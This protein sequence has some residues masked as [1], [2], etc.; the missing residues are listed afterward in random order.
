MDSFGE[1]LRRER[2]LR[3]VT[4][5]EIAKASNISKTFLKSL[6]NDDFEN[7]PSEVFVKGFIRCYAENTGMDGSEAVLAYNSFIENKRTSQSTSETSTEIPTESN[8]KMSYFLVIVIF[9]VVSSLMVF[10]YVKKNREIKPPF[11]SEE[12]ISQRVDEIGIVE[13]KNNISI[14]LAPDIKETE[15]LIETDDLEAQAEEK[16][17][18]DNLSLPPPTG[19]E[20]TSEVSDKKEITDTLT[21]TVEAKENAWL[22]LIIDDA[23]TKEALLIP[24]ETAK[25]KAKEKFVVNLGNVAGTHLKLNGKEISLPKTSSNVLRNFTITLD[26]IN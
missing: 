3:G 18:S 15:N 12:K 16:D 7:L 14:T 23:V 25:W 9:V 2:E 21:L 13:S 22:S 5:D 8:M 11:A 20:E 10:Y 4:L 17:V 6:E 19:N 24:G 26:N 1:Y